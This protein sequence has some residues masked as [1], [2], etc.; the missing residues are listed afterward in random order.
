MASDLSSNDIGLEDN[1][2]RNLNESLDQENDAD[3]NLN[4]ERDTGTDKNTLKMDYAKAV[5]RNIVN[6]SSSTVDELK[7][8]FFEHVAQIPSS[9]IIM[10]EDR[11][12]TPMEKSWG[13]C[14]AGVCLGRF[15]G[16]MAIEELANQWPT[17]PRVSCH[18]NGVSLFRFKTREAMLNVFEK[19]PYYVFDRPI[20]LHLIDPNFSFENVIKN[21]VKVWVSLLNLPLELWNPTAMGKILSRV[22]KP[23]MMDSYTHQKKKPDCARI[24]VE[25]DPAVPPPTCLEFLS[26]SNANISINILYDFVPKLCTSCNRYGHYKDNCH[27]K[28]SGINNTEKSDKLSQL[29]N[30][31]IKAAK[32]AA[33]KLINIPYKAGALKRMGIKK[34]EEIRNSKLIQDILALDV[35]STD[36][37]EHLK[38]SEIPNEDDPTALDFSKN[39]LKSMVQS[40]SNKG[41]SLMLSDEQVDQLEANQCHNWLNH[42]LIR[43]LMSLDVED[44]ETHAELQLLVSKH[45]ELFQ[46]QLDSPKINP[47]VNQEGPS[48]QSTDFGPPVQLVA[49]NSQV[50]ELLQDTSTNPELHNEVQVVNDSSYIPVGTADDISTSVTVSD[51][52]LQNIGV[53]DSNSNAFESPYNSNYSA[54]EFCKPNTPVSTQQPVAIKCSEDVLN[55]LHDFYYTDPDFTKLTPIEIVNRFNALQRPKRIHFH[56]EVEELYKKKTQKNLNKSQKKKIRKKIKDLEKSDAISSTHHLFST[57]P[58]HGKK[59][60]DQ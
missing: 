41:L 7:V 60:C 50:N 12:Y 19:G 18:S 30:D 46:E 25:L 23:I 49:Q 55:K 17:K 34:K 31:L 43:C 20:V 10:F 27:A 6:K 13:Y 38:D 1:I 36:C 16:Y 3:M 14:L 28:K 5:K 15:P 29:D 2:A 54:W 40:C 39:L 42:P 53:E 21:D 57:P 26:P 22:G 56:K 32:S 45:P 11:D 4:L 51:P 48:P 9:D 44:R 52:D 24:L 33:N 8:P 37:P 47:E 58:R 35:D 59:V